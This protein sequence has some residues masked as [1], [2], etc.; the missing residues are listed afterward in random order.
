MSSKDNTTSTLPSHRRAKSH[1][2]RSTTAVEGPRPSLPGSIPFYPRV[3]GLGLGF[4]SPTEPGDLAAAQAAPVS[5]AGEQPILGTD[6]EGSAGEGAVSASPA[7]W[8]QV[9]NPLPTMATGAP[10]PPIIKGVTSSDPADLEAAAAAAPPQPPLSKVATQG[11]GGSSSAAVRSHEAVASSSSAF[12][13]GGSTRTA[14]REDQD[15]VRPP[16]RPHPPQLLPGFVSPRSRR[17]AR[18]QTGAQAGPSSNAGRR[19]VTP[20]HQVIPTYDQRREA[21]DAWLR[22]EELH[23][24]EWERQQERQLS[25][26]NGSAWHYPVGAVVRRQP[27]VVAGPRAPIAPAA[28]A[29]AGPAFLGRP[30]GNSQAS[31]I[32]QA[33]AFGNVVPGPSHRARFVSV[34]AGGYGAVDDRQTR[35]RSPRTAAVASYADSPGHGPYLGGSR[36]EG[37]GAYTEHPSPSTP[38]GMTREMYEMMCAFSEDVRQEQEDVDEEVEDEG[39]AAAAAAAAEAASF[40]MPMPGIN[41]HG[42]LELLRGLTRAEFEAEQS[43]LMAD[44]LAFSELVGAEEEEEKEVAAAAAQEAE[45]RRRDA[46]RHRHPRVSSPGAASASSYYGTGTLD[47]ETWQA[48][49]DELWDVLNRRRVPSYD[50]KG[51]LVFPTSPSAAEIAR[52]RAAIF[53]RARRRAEEAVGGASQGAGWGGEG[54]LDRNPPQ[55]PFGIPE[56]IYDQACA[57]NEQVRQEEADRERAEGQAGPSHTSPLP[58]PLACPPGLI[59]WGVTEEGLISAWRNHVAQ[60]P[61]GPHG[62]PAAGSGVEQHGAQPPPV[63]HHDPFDERDVAA[64]SR[65]TAAAA[66]SGILLGRSSAR[67]SSARNATRGSY[68]P[69]EISTGSPRPRGRGVVVGEYVAPPEQATPLPARRRAMRTPSPSVYSRTSG[70]GTVQAAVQ[71]PVISGVSSPDRGDVFGSP[72]IELAPVFAGIQR[73]NL[74]SFNEQVN[75]GSDPVDEDTSREGQEKEGV[76]GKMVIRNGSAARASSSSLSDGGGHASRWVYES[77]SIGKMDFGPPRDK[78]KRAATASEVAAQVVEEEMLLLGTSASPAATEMER[79][80]GEGEG[81]IRPPSPAVSQSE[82]LLDDSGSRDELPPPPPSPTPPPPPSSAAA[83]IL[84]PLLAGAHRTL[85]LDEDFEYDAGIEAAP[86]STRRAKVTG[87]L[88]G[89]AR[90]I[91]DALSSSSRK[92]AA[93]PPPQQAA[94]VATPRPEIVDGEANQSTATG[95]SV[96]GRPGVF[97]SLTGRFTP[98]PGSSASAHRAPLAKVSGTGSLGS[99]RWPARRSSLARAFSIPNLRSP[100]LTAGTLNKPLPQTPLFV[101]RETASGDEAS[102]TPDIG[103]SVESVG[104]L[105]PVTAA[106][107]GQSLRRGRYVSFADQ[108][109][110]TTARW[111]RSSGS[112][113]E[114]V[115]RGEEQKEE[116][117]P[118]R[119]QQ[120]QRIDDLSAAL[121]DAESSRLAAEARASAA[122]AELT[123]AHAELDVYVAEATV[124]QRALTAARVEFQLQLDLARRET[125]RHAA[126]T[127][128]QHERHLDYLRVLAEAHGAER[129]GLEAQIAMLYSAVGGLQ[130]QLLYAGVGVPQ[131]QQ[132]GARGARQSLQ[133]PA[134]PAAAQQEEGTAANEPLPPPQQPPSPEFVYLGPRHRFGSRLPEPGLFQILSHPIPLPPQQP[135]F[136]PSESVRLANRAGRLAAEAGGAEYRQRMRRRQVPDSD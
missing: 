7:G 39:E 48:A 103:E 112:A 32:E 3:F 50:E 75:S 10:L 105:R 54:P 123:R 34:P 28:A 91:K 59:E 22:R 85:D 9:L 136:A 111:L 106:V 33:S 15:R 115:P 98:R 97:A 44:A 78:G 117:T 40:R 96:G 38:E 66:R 86:K 118:V 94:A 1:D 81:V 49:E 19:P 63:H 46:N 26:F 55:I 89:F 16:T 68:Y 104:F 101:V 83:P 79:D 61:A 65:S 8:S 127:E 121:E 100:S 47:A 20:V 25:E 107:E 72:S 67:R 23:R 77:P 42:H 35:I 135:P 62:P 124:A 11:P 132:G 108:H 52:E 60:Q 27:F 126:E 69:A 6:T 12:S 88:R 36:L 29:A 109:P 58:A 134:A 87:G 84:V 130:T 43:Q 53:K 45:D 51:A 5:S 74:A 128:R 57:F 133:F 114:I 17:D 14:V 73:R 18:I 13:R 129:Q 119:A 125:E 76:K 31:A 82:T 80:E 113:H 122:E 4:E 110:S 70:F 21:E 41:Q 64:I 93:R 71:R 24:R 30:R 99:R 37:Q 56:D 131:Q 90:G 95:L 2:V 92:A 120:Q 102:S 116:P